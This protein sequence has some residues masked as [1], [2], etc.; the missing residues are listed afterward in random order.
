MKYTGPKPAENETE[1]A[2]SGAV[3]IDLVEALAKIMT[4]AGLTEIEVA[5]G[6]LKIRV[7]R[8]LV[9]S[10]PPP[11]AP[12][13]VAAAPIPTKASAAD[14][15]GAV[16]SPMVGTA[17]LRA[18]PESPPFVE[19]GSIV[20][21]GDKILLVEAMKTFNEIVAPRSGVVVGVLVEDGQPVE[22][23]QPLFVIE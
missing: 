15:P 18:S 4:R 20:K 5:Q 7:A 9:A 13:P 12:A 10:A 23:G 17:Y 6:D 11:L 1:S 2:A 22:Y 14:A 16:K 21:A 19:V 3:D 8:Q